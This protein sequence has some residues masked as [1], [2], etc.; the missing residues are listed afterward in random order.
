MLR[1]DFLQG[2]SLT[3]LS[4]GVMACARAPSKPT[5]AATRIAFGSCADQNFAQPIWDSIA[6][7]NPDVFVFLGDNIY[8]DTE[9]MNSMMAEYQKFAANPD[10]D[11]F[12]RKIPVVATWDD[13]DY[14]CNDSGCEYPR[15]RESKALMLNFFGEPQNS[16]RRTREGIYTSYFLG[17]PPHRTQIILLDLR[18]FRTA[19]N[20]N[21]DLGY[22]PT[23]DPAAQLLG[24]IQWH[25]L[26]QQLRIPAD[27][28]VIGSSIQFLSSEHRWEKWANFPRERER[29]IRLIEH[30]NLRDLTIISGDMHFGEI[31]RETLANGTV[32]LDVTSS[33]L[34]RSEPAGEIP[35]S[36]RLHLF[37]GECNFGMI[38]LNGSAGPRMTCEV[39]DQN[40]VV[41][42]TAVR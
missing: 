29:L 33:G 17:E 19:L 14:G 12:R 2:V 34:N 15:R 39:F 21:P 10:F 9:D 35:N 1:R 42:I 7:K 41:R 28:R 22:G 40:G 31:S 30:L 16:P 38:T 11:R 13:H 36:R 4:A 3:A 37:E 25:W 26:E 8:A 5:P 20:V 27:F 24:D 6:A 18:W 23:Q 32:L